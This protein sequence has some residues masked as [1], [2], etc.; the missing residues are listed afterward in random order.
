MTPPHGNHQYD[1]W[2][3]PDGPGHRIENRIAEL[4]RKAAKWGG[5]AAVILGLLTIISP[6]IKDSVAGRGISQAQAASKA[7]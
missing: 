2:G 6:W 7:P 3:D 1:C 4:E 5:I